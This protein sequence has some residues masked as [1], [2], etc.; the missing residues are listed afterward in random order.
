MSSEAIA[1]DIETDAQVSSG[2]DRPAG[3]EL[4]HMSDLGDHSGVPRNILVRLLLTEGEREAWQ[5]A[6]D[7]AGLKLSEWIRRRVQGTVTIEAPPPP[8]KGRR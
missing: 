8:R 7:A 4:P 6:A 1:L 5:A 2:A 3:A